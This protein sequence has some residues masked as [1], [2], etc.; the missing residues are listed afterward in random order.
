MRDFRRPSTRAAAE[1][2][3]CPRDGSGCVRSAPPFEALGFRPGKLLAAPPKA[4]TTN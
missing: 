4:L 3:R 1:K 2:L